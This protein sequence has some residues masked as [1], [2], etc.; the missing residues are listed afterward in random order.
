MNREE[1]DEFEEDDREVARE[2]F[3]KLDLDRSGGLNSHEFRNAIQ[4]YTLPH[5]MDLA[6]A[7]QIMMDTTSAGV[8][9][10]FEDFYAAVRE[11]P[12]ARGQRVLWVRTLGLE[13]ELARLLK[14]GEFFDG[15]RGLREMTE[16]DIRLVCDGFQ[17]RLFEILKFNLD[18][19]KEMVHVDA[20]HYKNTKFAMDGTEFEGSFAELEQFYEG[21]EK[22][23]GTPNPNAE[24]GIKREHCERSKSS[25]TYKSPNYNF[26]FTPKLEYEFVN[27]PK[28]GRA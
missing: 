18:K 23:I 12:R 2:L 28:P 25:H 5:E 11:L 20:E 17:E 4:Q 19:L 10:S 9:M 22:F 24:E 21:P 1:I 26:E 14:K 27:D 3:D 8:D 7:L 15:L 16:D 6:G 13:W